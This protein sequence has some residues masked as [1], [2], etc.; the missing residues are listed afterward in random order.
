[1]KVIF[2]QNLF[3]MGLKKNLYDINRTYALCLE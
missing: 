1:M 3:D 2:F